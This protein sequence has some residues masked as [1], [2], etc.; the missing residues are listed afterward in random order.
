M[1]QFYGQTDL[2]K[3]TLKMTSKIKWRMVYRKYKH[4]PVKCTLCVETLNEMLGKMDE[5]S[6]TTRLMPTNEGAVG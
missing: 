4:A 3:A 6:G 5:D 2:Q 1:T